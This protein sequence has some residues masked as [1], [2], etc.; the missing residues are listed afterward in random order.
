MEGSETG[1]GRLWTVVWME[2][3]GSVDVDGRRREARLGVD[4]WTVVW[5]EDGG[6]RDLVWTGVDGCGRWCGV[7]GVDEI[8]RGRVW[9][10]DGR[11][12][13]A[14]L[15]VE[16]CGRCGAVWT[17]V[18]ME[19]RGERHWVWT[20]VGGV[21]GCGRGKRGLVELLYEACFRVSLKHASAEIFRKRRLK[22]LQMEMH[23]G[24][25]GGSCGWTEAVYEACF[26]VSL[27]HASLRAEIFKK[28]RLKGLQMEMILGE[29]GGSCGWTEAVYEACFRVSLKHA[30]LWAE[31][32]KEI[33][34]EGV[35]DGDDPGGKGG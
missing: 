28:L 13:G 3:G 20:G 8:G 27:K 9:M 4:V 25:R 34:V 26:R 32:F 18:W 10:E 23:P 31:I 29:R 15:G 11:R 5:M 12:R 30:S 6:E 22:G 19:D 24:G 33:E 35:A 14:R 1:C 17:G 2:D 7:D 21:G 16:G